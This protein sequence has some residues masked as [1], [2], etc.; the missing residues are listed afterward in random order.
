V[1]QPSPARL[2]LHV[3]EAAETL[4][5][6]LPPLAPLCQAFE[7]TTGWELRFEKSPPGIGEVWSTAIGSEPLPAGRLVLAVADHGMQSAAIPL[8]AARPLALAI[9]GLLGEIHRLRG[10]L[11]H[12]EAELAAGVPVT[13]RPDEP[14]LAERLEAV[15][16]G[17]AAAVGCQAAGLYLLDEGTSELKLRAAF[18]LPHERL[19]AP[20]RPL[21]GAVADLE[22]LVGH[23]VVLE[24]TALLPHWR[25]PEDYPSAVCVPV[26]SPTIPLGTLWAF[27]EQPRD[28]SPEH[29][30]LLEIIAGRLA[31][32]LEREMLLAA[33]AQ[34]NRDSQQ[35]SVAARWLSDR[36]PTVAPLLD[37]FEVAGWT[38]SADEIGG[39]FH[40]WSVLPDGRLALAV[41]AAEG[42]L[43]TSALGAASLHSAIKAHAGHRHT[44][45]GLA[46]QVNET[47][48]TA[49]PGDQHAGLAYALLDPDSGQAELALAGG[50]AA[51]L[52]RPDERCI[53]TADGRPLGSDSDPD[54]M[55]EKIALVRDEALLLLSPGVRSALDAAGLRIGENA[56]ASLLGRHLRESAVDLAARLRRLLDGGT[57]SGDMTLLLIKRRQTH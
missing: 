42:R 22:A 23:A 52:V 47:L 28:F 57:T 33:G 39:S 36:L 54:V 30:N 12:R 14:H 35:L 10:E 17:G 51:I 6:A 21:R 15:L 31:A 4:N 48:W 40:D 49:F 46:R 43:L 7:Q 29:T 44:A 1:T 45:G 27:S 50:T 2:R 16:K 32:D 41:G 9:G 25:C 11:R 18:G 20:A 24:D 8:A 5:P 26:A 37:E 53:L 19:L 13:A 3:E 55:C 34:A 56:I 38:Q